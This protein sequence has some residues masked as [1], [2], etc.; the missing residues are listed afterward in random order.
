MLL[1]KGWKPRT[2][3]YANRHLEFLEAPRS[4]EASGESGAGAEAKAETKKCYVYKAVHDPG[5]ASRGQL[6]A[7]AKR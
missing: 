6:R 3:V 4:S 2:P 5:L 1:Q 7:A